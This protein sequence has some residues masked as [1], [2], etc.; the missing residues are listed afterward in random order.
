MHS[1][2]SHSDAHLQKGL[3]KDDP[4]QCGLSRTSSQHAFGKRTSYKSRAGNY[5]GLIVSGSYV[6]RVAF[7]L[8]HILLSQMCDCIVLFIPALDANR[9]MVPQ[10]SSVLADLGHY[11]NLKR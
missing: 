7:G 4:G 1:W 5:D 11:I 6:P 2:M 9:M 8:H 10:T 3:P